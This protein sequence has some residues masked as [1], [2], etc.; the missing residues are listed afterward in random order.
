M[1]EDQEVTFTVTS[2]PLLLNTGIPVPDGTMYSIRNVVAAGSSTVPY[3]ELL[4]S[5]ADVARDN[6]QVAASD[7]RITFQIRY[8]A[9]NNVYVPGRVVV[10]STTGTAYGGLILEK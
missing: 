5:D 1:S 2:G 9:P 4:V 6:V 3:G 8:P 10:Y 7:G